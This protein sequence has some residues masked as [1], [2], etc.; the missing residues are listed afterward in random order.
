MDDPLR[1][2]VCSPK[3]SGHRDKGSL[4]AAERTHDSVPTPY[5]A[6]AHFSHMKLKG[7]QKIHPDTGSPHLA[8]VVLFIYLFGFHVPMSSGAHTETTR[9]PKEHRLLFTWSLW[10]PNDLQPPETHSRSSL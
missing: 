10:T 5:A 9:V 4:S 7:K 1:W 8:A 2:E 6:T 3:L